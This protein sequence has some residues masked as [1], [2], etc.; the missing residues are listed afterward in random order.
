MRCFSMGTGR[1]GA[2]KRIDVM[3]GAFKMERI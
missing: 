1:A 2:I 3:I